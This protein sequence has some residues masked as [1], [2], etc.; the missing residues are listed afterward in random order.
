MRLL[1]AESNVL[2]KDNEPLNSNPASESGINE[3]DDCPMQS[4]DV[5]TPNIEVSNRFSAL[6][7]EENNKG[8]ATF[9][10]TRQNQ[11]PNKKKKSPNQIKSKLQM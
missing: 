4:R 8:D 6:A 2:V 11:M 3:A 1:V 10:D 5:L 7:V 9:E